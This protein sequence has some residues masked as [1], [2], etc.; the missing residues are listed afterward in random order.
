[1]QT[2]NGQLEDHEEQFDEFD[3]KYIGLEWKTAPFYQVST[4][5]TFFHCCVCV[6][7]IC[8]AVL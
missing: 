2:L 5:R 7:H 1:M 4:A 6:I 3:Q 8:F